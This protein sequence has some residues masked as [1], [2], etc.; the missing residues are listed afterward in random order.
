MEEIKKVLIVVDMQNDFVTG[1]LRNEEAIKIVPDVINKVKKAKDNKDTLIVFTQ[2]THKENYMKTQE[3][4][5]LPI[6]HCIK[7]TEGWEIIDELKP[8]VSSE[9]RW[10]PFEKGTFGS[11][12]LGEELKSFI[13][14]NG[15]KTEKIEFIGLCTDI[16]VLSNATLVKAFLPEIPIE[17]DATCCAGVTPESHDTALNAMKA[18]QIRVTGQGEE[19]WR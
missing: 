9:I 14:T 2:D 18:I 7:G 15:V 13:R 3:G 17:V 4:K 12:V 1:A 5:N 19:A 10:L 16:C 8:F 6:P 11:V